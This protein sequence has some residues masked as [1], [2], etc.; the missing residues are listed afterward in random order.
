MKPIRSTGI[1]DLSGKYI[2]EGDTFIA[3]MK[4]EEPL[5]WVCVWIKEYARFAWLM[6]EERKA[7]ISTED[8]YETIDKS[9]GMDATSSGKIKVTGNIYKKK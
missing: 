7:Y 4:D 1:K 9:M 8:P 3:P 5:L 2:L 6:D